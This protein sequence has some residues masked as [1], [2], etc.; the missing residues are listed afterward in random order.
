MVCFYFFGASVAI[1]LQDRLL[2]S[3]NPKKTSE[4]IMNGSI[5]KSKHCFELIICM[6]C[7]WSFSMYIEKT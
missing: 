1:K 3:T 7:F 6:I 2:I 5:Y 4:N